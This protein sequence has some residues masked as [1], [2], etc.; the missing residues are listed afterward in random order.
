MYNALSSELCPHCGF[1]YNLLLAV[2]MISES[3]CVT[4]KDL[5][6]HLL[7]DYILFLDLVGV[8]LLVDFSGHV[9]N[10]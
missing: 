6:I 5:S 2:W 4:S 9:D 3:S 1:V 10:V 8:M 7:L